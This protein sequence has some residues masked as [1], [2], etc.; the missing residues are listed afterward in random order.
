MQNLGKT[1]P[2]MPNLV[3]MANSPTRQGLFSRRRY[4]YLRHFR[5]INITGVHLGNVKIIVAFSEA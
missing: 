3:F 5:V 4:I 1:V 2:L